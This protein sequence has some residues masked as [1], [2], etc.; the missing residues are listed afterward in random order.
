MEHDASSSSLLLRLPRAGSAASAA[1]ISDVIIH[2]LMMMKVIFDLRGSLT[3]SLSP[4]QTRRFFPVFKRSLGSC[5][6]PSSIG[7]KYGMRCGR[8]A[9][10]VSFIG[11]KCRLVPKLPPSLL[12]L[13][14]FHHRLTLYFGRLISSCRRPC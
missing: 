8:C 5:R 14:S 13:P 12:R 10:P 7:K 3:P 11:D 6:F 1:A 4:K 9:W 2:L